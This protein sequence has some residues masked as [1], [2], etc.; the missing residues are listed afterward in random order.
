[1][2]PYDKITWL[3]AEISNKCNAWCP[4]CGRNQNGYGLKNDLVLQDISP[5]EFWR[6][7]KL[8]PNLKTV[9]FCGTYGDPIASAWADV[10]I[11]GTAQKDLEVR[12]HTNGSLKHT[13]WWR[14][15]AQELRGYN[16]TVI[17]GIDGLEGVHEIHRQGTNFKKIMEN[18]AA[19]IDEDGNAEWQFLLFK[20][21]K[22]QVK[23]CMRLSQDMGFKKFTPKKSIRLPNPARNFQTGEPYEIEADSDF[24][25]IFNKDQKELTVDDCMHLSMPSIY[26]NADGTLAPCCYLTDIA[27]PNNNIDIEI[28]SDR[29]NERCR[30]SCGRTTVAHK[31]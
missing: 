2:L 25:D 28:I 1:M 31:N 4:A 26:M 5:N 3:H 21:N 24:A 8:F 16:H 27:Y 14:R 19:F 23:D 6:I 9:Q 12:V 17:F 30:N 15:L 29:A 22:H 11:A 20:H 13:L 10:I 18:A 7:L